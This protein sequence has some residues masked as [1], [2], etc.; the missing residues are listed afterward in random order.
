MDTIEASKYLPHDTLSSLFMF[1]PELV[2]ALSAIGKTAEPLRV[3]GPNQLMPF[4]HS[5]S[6]NGTFEDFKMVWDRIAEGMTAYVR[7]HGDEQSDKCIL[8]EPVTG[9]VEY[10]TVCIHVHWPWIAY[11]AAVVIL[12][13]T[14]FL[15]TVF[16]TKQ[17][18]AYLLKDCNRAEGG[19]TLY[20]F[21]SSALALLIHGLDKDSLKSMAGVGSMNQEKELK[22]LS[23]KTKVQ[24]VPTEQGWK[25]S[26][27]H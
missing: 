19:A 13:L 6:G 26:T 20:D 1:T 22:K 8:N 9:R 11:S 5:G 16:Q 27:T 12:T 17:D 10:N 24:L 18:Q 2:P 3:I 7:Q 15:W 21:K 23:R 25:L 4:W 14:F